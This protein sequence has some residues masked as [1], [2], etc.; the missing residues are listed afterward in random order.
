M[1]TALGTITK[2]ALLNQPSRVF[3]CRFLYGN[4]L[5]AEYVAARIEDASFEKEAFVQKSDKDFQLAYTPKQL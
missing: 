2:I 3:E 4:Y 5:G 1:N